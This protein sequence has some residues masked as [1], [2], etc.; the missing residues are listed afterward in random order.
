MSKKMQALCLLLFPIF[1]LH[2]PYCVIAV[3]LYVFSLIF[4]SF[5][6]TSWSTVTLGNNIFVYMECYYVPITPMSNLWGTIIVILLDE[7]F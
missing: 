4:A 7:V 3:W 1:T 6:A 5:V 2:L